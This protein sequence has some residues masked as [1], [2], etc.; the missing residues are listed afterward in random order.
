MNY[1]AR[2]LPSLGEDSVTLRSIGAVASDVVRITGDRVDPPQVAAIKG[3]LR[4]VKLLRRLVHEPIQE[5][6]LEL[7]IMVDGTVL[8]LPTATLAR[9]RSRVLAHHRLNSGRE[10]AEREL[11]AALWRVRHPDSEDSIDHDHE[12][13][14]FEDRVSDLASFK[15]FCNAWWPAVSAPAALARL[16]DVELI[17]RV[18]TSSTL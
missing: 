5:V 9:I 18:A 16:A 6:P 4:M 1:I 8:V 2:V 12:R 11:L 10:A 17:K 15:M 13:E 7:R 3:S 14:E